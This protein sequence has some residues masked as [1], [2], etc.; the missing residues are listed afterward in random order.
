MTAPLLGDALAAY[1]ALFAALRPAD[2]ERFDAVYAPGAR[3]KDPFNDV[4]GVPAIRAVFAHMYSVAREPRFEILERALDG[5][6][7]F[8]R[9]RFHYRDG[10]G[11]PRSF[12]GVSCVRFDGAG[13]VSDHVDYWDPVEAIWGRV[14]LL[15]AALR[16]L[17]RR[18][19]APPPPA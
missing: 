9:W 6:T 8:V 11:A 12:D 16:R 13:R 4:R 14:P 7:G 3:F 15:G 17:G 10:G 5:G 1:C 2:L 18:L 19:A